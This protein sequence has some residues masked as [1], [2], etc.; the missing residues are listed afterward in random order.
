MG[1]QYSTCIH[2]YV[3]II[4]VLPYYCAIMYYIIIIIVC[5][6]SVY[7]GI[8]YSTYVHMCVRIY[9]CCIITCAII[10]YNIIIAIIVCA[11]RALWYWC[12]LLLHLPPVATVPQYF[13]FYTLERV[14]CGPSG[15]MA[16]YAI[17]DSGTRQHHSIPADLCGPEPDSRDDA[18][19]WRSACFC[20]FYRLST[21]F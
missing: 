3:R 21:T 9:L 11:F 15:N 18:Q 14:R 13:H 10:Y 4:P 8:Q 12:T 20:R 17:G 1:I 16:L 19:L 5:T 2:M 6:F 7:V